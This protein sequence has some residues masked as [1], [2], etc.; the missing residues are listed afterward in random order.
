MQVEFQFVNLSIQPC[1]YSLTALWQIELSKFGTTLNTADNTYSWSAPCSSLNSERRL[2]KPFQGSDQ[3][4][5]HFQK[6][7]AQ[8]RSCS[9]ELVQP[10]L[11]SSSVSPF[12]YCRIQYLKKEEIV[13]VF[14]MCLLTGV[15][16]VKKYWDSICEPLFQKENKTYCY[17]GL[18][19]PA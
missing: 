13:S 7:S 11:L 19:K 1:W 2:D 6:S 12:H 5:C 16:Y 14:Q 4:W 8:W 15:Q 9:P 3:L 18:E 10:W 17:T